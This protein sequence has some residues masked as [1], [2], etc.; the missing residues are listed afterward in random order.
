[1]A[2]AVSDSEKQAAKQ[3]PKRRRIL[4][5][6][7]IVSVP[8]YSNKVSSSLQLKPTAEMFAG[9][10]NSDDV[11]DDSLWSPFSSPK[12]SSTVVIGLSDS[13]DE[14]EHVEKKTE[15]AAMR[16]RVLPDIEQYF[17]ID[18]GKSGLLQTVFICSYM[19]LAPV[20]GYLGDRY[21]RKFI[22]S[23]GISFWA[24]VTLASSYTP[25]EVCFFLDYS[26][27]G[28][29]VGSQVGNLAQD[30]HWALR[31]TPGLGLIRPSLL[32]LALSASRSLSQGVAYRPHAPTTGA[33]D[34][35]H[36][37]STNSH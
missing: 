10:E 31:V 15:P 8:V 35:L 6:S 37:P 34:P 3:P 27:L 17:G 25:K 21:N 12:R 7:A 13:E 23:V 29:I 30:W 14:A 16:C 36:H 22:M 11:A 1:M 9:K 24:L 18:D 32:L 33:G 2:D 4:D 5:P 26:G 20:F 28:Y 19:F